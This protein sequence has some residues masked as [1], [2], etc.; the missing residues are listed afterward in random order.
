V[1]TAK[2]QYSL[3]NAQSY[4]AEHLAVATI[5]RRARRSPANGLAS[6]R[7]RWIE[8]VIREADFSRCVKSKSSIRRHVVQRTN[9]VREEDG[10][11]TANR[12]IF[13]DFT[14]PRPNPFGDGI[15]GG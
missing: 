4:F 10:K 15:T 3:N 12:R 11:T 9:T 1:V 5:I 14:F 8:G 13:Y 2:T 7:S 6:A